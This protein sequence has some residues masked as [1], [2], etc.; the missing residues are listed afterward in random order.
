M[1]ALSLAEVQYIAFSL[2]REYLTFDEPIPD[3]TTRYPD[4]LESC[5]AQPF[6]KFSKKYLYGGLKHK[7]AVLF[8][9]MIKNHPFQN[10][11][12]RLA[13]TTLMTLLYK[14]KKWLKVDNREFYDLALLAAKS[15]PGL[16]D[17]VILKTEKFIKKHIVD[18]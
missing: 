3:F 13:M 16:K 18:L 11:N 6:Q 14:N 17:E 15:D 7:A 10:G 1:K 9:F 5:L 12:K 4:K 2:A 8:Y